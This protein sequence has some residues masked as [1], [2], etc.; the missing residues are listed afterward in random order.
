MDS[1]RKHEEFEMLVLAAL[2]SARILPELMF[3]GATMLRLCHGLDR[4]SIDL[5]FHLLKSQPPAAF[6][7]RC[8]GA[9]ATHFAITDAADK[10]NTILV[11]LSS[12]QSPR[13]LKI[14]INKIRTIKSWKKEIAWSPFSSLQVLVNAVT[15]AEM[16]QMK[17][18]ALLARK[19]IRDAYDLEFLVKKQVHIPGDAVCF[20][21]VLSVIQGF[22][23]QDYSVKLGSIIEEEKRRYYIEN[24]FRVLTTYLAERIRTD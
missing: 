5:D 20:Q 10:R 1:L 11:E 22:G 19:E 8:L 9:L 18:E 2:N 14:E 23:R 12:T 4:Y 3:G 16:A 17:V 7:T 21:K 15:L 24:H 6:L 13:K